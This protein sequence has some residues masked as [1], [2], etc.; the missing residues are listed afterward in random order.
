MN[1]RPMTEADIEACDA[2]TFAAFTELEER[3]HFE[4]VRHSDEDARRRRA[5]IRMRHLLT[6][7]PGGCFVAEDD[8]DVV[9]VGLSLRR[10][11]VWGLSL[12][13]VEPRA[14]EKRAGSALL[15]ATLAYGDGCEGGVI[16]SSPDARAMR[17]YGRAGFA[18]VPIAWASGPVDRATLPAVHGVREAAA[19]DLDVVTAVDAV[20][21]GGSH[22]VDIPPLLE[23]GRRWWVA[24]DGSGYAVADNGSVDLLAATSERVAQSLLWTALAESEDAATAV[25][26]GLAH[27]QKWA[28]DVVLQAR[29]Q[30][31]PWVAGRF[32][33]GRLGTM[34]P[35]LPSGAYL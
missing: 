20:V 7:D 5:Q 18:F 26:T 11:P 29:L 12:L 14:Q 1:V 17:A 9:G 33:R 32:T 34:T 30:L 19:A 6:T 31:M 35:Y 27:D 25:V 28:M 3:L 24:G 16:L 15:A 10:G 8:S 2:V 13:T 23:A 4:P 22:A 21:R